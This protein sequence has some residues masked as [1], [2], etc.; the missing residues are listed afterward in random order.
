MF[1]ISQIFCPFNRTRESESRLLQNAKHLTQTL[2]KFRAN[3]EDADNFPENANS[4]VAKM[5]MT[6]LQHN[7]EINQAEERNYQNDF[8]LD[9][10]V[11]ACIQCMDRT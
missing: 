2:D 7:N 10:F 6:L 8:K 11:N 4:E 1:N 3:L 5:R 9:R